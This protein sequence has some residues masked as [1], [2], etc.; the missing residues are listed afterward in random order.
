VANRAASSVEELRRIVEAV[1]AG[2]ADTAEA[3]C[4]RHVEE[5]GRIGLQALA[6]NERATA[7]G[8]AARPG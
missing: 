4:R 7:R 2:D 6:D 8:G 3:A 5:A 1:R